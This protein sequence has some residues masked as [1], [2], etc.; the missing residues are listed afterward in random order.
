M[1]KL[2]ALDPAALGIELAT[3]GNILP[4]LKAYKQ[5]VAGMEGATYYY[6][7]IPKNPVNDWLVAEH[8]KRF[9][10]PPDFFT[11]GGMSTGIALVTALEKTEGDSRHRDA[12]H[13]HGR[14]GVRLAQGPMQFRPED[15][16]ALQS[17]YGF[18]LKVDAAA[19][20]A[21]PVLTREFGI[22]DMSIPIANRR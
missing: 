15:H 4:V 14:H 3:G 10:R 6:Y 13:G 20:W 8:Q 7:G 5:L 9:G 19:P 1:A 22:G 21:V 11:A 12:D 16:Q 2:A 18:S 17:M